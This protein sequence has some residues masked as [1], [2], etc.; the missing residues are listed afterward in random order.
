M[1]R[2][3]VRRLRWPD[4][5]AVHQL[6][7]DAFPDT[8]WSVEAFWAELARVPESRW[9]VV[10]E[11]AELAGEV[12]GYA[13]LMVVGAQGDVQTIAVDADRRGCGVG[14]LLLDALVAE[15]SRRGCTSLLLEVA[16]DNRAAQSLYRTRGFE[17]IARRSSYYGPGRDAAVMRL[18][19]PGASTGRGAAS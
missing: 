7:L 10:A 15:A 6:E 9:Y 12:V 4:L 2:A 19:L 17:V 13:G 18:R 8:A 3:R 14:G 16:A 5:P 1:S 11:P